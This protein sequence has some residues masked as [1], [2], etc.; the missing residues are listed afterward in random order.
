MVVEL[1]VSGC[2]K[3]KVESWKLKVEGWKL[4]VESWRKY[5]RDVGKVL[6]QF[7]FISQTTEFLS[8]FCSAIGGHFNDCVAIQLLDFTLVQEDKVFC[9]PLQFLVSF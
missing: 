9:G 3:L 4:K 1:F 7:F 5:Y 8:C 6:F 2:L